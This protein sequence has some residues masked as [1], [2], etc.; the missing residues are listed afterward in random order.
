[1]PGVSFSRETLVAAADLLTSS[2]H[3][4]ID[5]FILRLGLEREIPGS[6]LTISAKARRLATI[7][8]NGPNTPVEMADGSRT[9][10]EALVRHAAR[11]ATPEPEHPRQVAFA[12]GLTRDGLMLSWKEGGGGTLRATL[13]TDTIQLPEADDEVHELLSR[14]GF[15]EPLG[16]LT[17]AIQAHATRNWASANSQLRTFLQ[18]LLDQIAIYLRPGQAEGLNSEGRRALLAQIEFLSIPRNEWTQDG[19][20]YVNGVFKMLHTEGSHPGLSDEDHSTFRLHVVLITARTF[21][22]RLAAQ[23]RSEDRS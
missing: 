2:S 11:Y 8:V 23:P 17:Q 10:G 21:L 18:G 3:H 15:E 5:F 12:Q 4:D 22:R 13:P 14:F 19:K 9:Y 20:N 7:V 1:M 16:H 6:G